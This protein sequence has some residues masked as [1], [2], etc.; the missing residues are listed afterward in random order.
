MTDEMTTQYKRLV[1]FLGK[2][3]G[4]DYEITLYDLEAESKPLVAIANGRING[5]NAGESLPDYALA[6]M[7]EEQADHLVNISVQ[8]D[9]GKTLRFSAMLL[10]NEAGRICALLGITFDDSRYLALCGKLFGMIHPDAYVQMRYAETGT[11]VSD[12]LLS[13]TAAPENIAGIH[14]DVSTLAAELFSKAA[15]QYSL[16]VDRLT[17]EE[18]IML[19]GQLQE[20]GMFRLKGAVQYVA[21]KLQCSQASVYRY[22]SKIR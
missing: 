21:Q 12:V 1:E 6:R 20:E 14:N 2:M 18:R 15:A 3:L 5:K 16:P 11:S 8:Q 10:H 4:P 9:S 22:L 7:H 19:I 13:G 17:Q